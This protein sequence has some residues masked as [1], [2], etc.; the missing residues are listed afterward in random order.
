MTNAESESV[1]SDFLLE[2]SDKVTEYMKQVHRGEL[3]N[4]GLSL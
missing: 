4:T 2:D 1:P 3:T